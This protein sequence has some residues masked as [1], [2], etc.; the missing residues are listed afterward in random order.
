VW[1]NNTNKET[2]LNEQG[3]SYDAG[4]RSHSDVIACGWLHGT[5]ND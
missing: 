5:Q 1:K 3:H 4:W 2:K